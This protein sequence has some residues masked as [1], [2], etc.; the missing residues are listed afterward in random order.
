MKVL[1]CTFSGTGNTFLAADSIAE[2][3]RALGVKIEQIKIEDIVSIKS[4]LYLDDIDH[5]L[6]GYPIHAFNTPKI[7]VDFAKNLPIVNG[8]K[9]SIFKTSGEPFFF[10]DS[11]SHMLI[12]T[13]EPKGYDFMLEAHFLMPYNIMFRY[14]DALAKQ[15][16]LKTLEMS[17]GF[18]EGIL[19]GNHGM[20]KYGAFNKFISFILRIQWGGARFNG[21]LYSCRHKKCT[22]C[23][24][25]VNNCPSGNIRKSEG[26]I[27]FD[28]KCLMCMRCVQNCPH[29]AI[30]IGILRWWAVRGGYNF[31]RLVSD[32]SIPGDYVNENTRGYFRLFRSFFK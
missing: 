26:K 8:I 23:M 7:V 14:P 32:S 9:V 17:A 31:K 25:C 18:A 30:N 22:L 19:N 28:G 1:I 21:R 5:L 29:A 3:L 11:S 10:N 4:P 20:I 13:L 24:K 15:M 2:S 6:I 27:R 12:K 16:Y